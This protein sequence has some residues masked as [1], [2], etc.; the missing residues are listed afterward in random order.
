M[1]INQIFGLL[2]L[3]FAFASCKPSKKSDDKEE[4]VQ[5]Y[6]HSDYRASVPKR[7]DLIS[8]TLYLEPDF[9]RREIKGKAKIEVKPH[10]YDQDTLILDAKY[11]DIESVN[12]V[13][14]AN[15]L[16][17]NTDLE[18]GLLYT[19]DSLKLKIVLDR[20]YRKDEKLTI[21]VRYTAKPES[22]KS[23]GSAA[24]TAAKG[25]YFINHDGSNP[26]KPVQMWT[27]GETEAASCWFPTIDAPNQKMVQEIHVR[28][29]KKFKTISNGKLIASVEDSSKRTDTWL[30]ELPHAPYLAALVVGDFA[31]IKDIWRQIPV[32]YYVEHPYA[33]YAKTVF[34]NTPQMIEFYGQL[35]GVPY[36]W[37]KYH[38]VVVREFVSGAME[39]TGCVVHFDPLQH[40]TRQHLDQTYENVI[41]H[42]LFHHW[43]GDLVTCESWSNLLLNESF[44]TY[45][46]YLWSEFKYGRDEAD[47][48]LA[49]FQEVAKYTNQ[50]N[51]VPMIRYDYATQEDMFDGNSYHKGGAVLHMLRKYMGDKAFFESLKLYLNRYKYAN[52]EL[53]DLRKCFEEITGEDL[54]WFFNQWFIEKGLPELEVKILRTPSGFSIDLQQKGEFFRL[55]FDVEVVGKNGERKR[56]RC[57]MEK[58]KQSFAVQAGSEDA[59][60][61]DSENQILGEIK[62]EQAD[63]L[64]LKAFKYARLAAHKSSAFEH[65][66]ATPIS[67]EEKNALITA[68]LNHPFYHCRAIAIESISSNDFQVRLNALNNGKARDLAIKDSSSMVRAACAEIVSFNK[69]KE[70]LGLML[71]DSSY[72]VLNRS[73]GYLYKLDQ[74][75]AES[76]V[77]TMRKSND[78][79][80]RDIAMT[81]LAVNSQ[82]DETDYFLDNVKSLREDQMG[83]VARSLVLYFSRSENTPYMSKFML[84]L[85]AL[86]EVGDKRASANASKVLND[87]NAY[88]QQYLYYYE[89]I[90]NSDK[91]KKD[92]AATKIEN[93]NKLIKSIQS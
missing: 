1:K 56:T 33:P 79:N 55:P 20:V 64:W 93:L 19:Y 86:R 18:V 78:P 21:V 65:L 58:M 45:G 5:R 34:G 62:L 3:P 59:I 91:T 41:A 17:I 69:D 29:D 38:Q 61:F 6:I 14:N 88:I 23:K 7:F 13:L 40:N 16:T 36:V 47:E 67:D 43:F 92:E 15:K 32:N 49:G 75:A 44:A 85:K 39:N 74:P 37:D 2:I 11:M 12:L 42:E 27:Q 70:T 71:G 51:P 22:V 10:F 53:S 31:E 28:V 76:M 24:I 63:D 8:T 25:V 57:V 81:K 4:K 82:K 35:L 73:L 90:K 52:A 68:M 60:I 89:Y 66:M 48:A 83:K 80:L 54:N 50:N 30:Q 46:E 72:T 87:L 9:L 26:D 84:A 77:E